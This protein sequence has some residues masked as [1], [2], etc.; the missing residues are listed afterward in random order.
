MHAVYVGHNILHDHVDAIICFCCCFC[1]FS[2]KSWILRKTRN[3]K[4]RRRVKRTERHQLRTDRCFLPSNPRV[5]S[6]Q[7]GQPKLV[8]FLSGTRRSSSTCRCTC[9]VPRTSTCH[10]TWTIAR[11]SSC[12]HVMEMTYN[13]IE[14]FSWL[15]CIRGFQIVVTSQRETSDILRGSGVWRSNGCCVNVTRSI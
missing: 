8:I 4:L 9:V 14:A 15:W 5:L 12:C 3:Q 11:A 2:R 10:C 6:F 7:T 13:M 1:R